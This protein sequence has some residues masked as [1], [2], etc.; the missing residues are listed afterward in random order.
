MSR[1]PDTFS[2]DAFDETLKIIR[3]NLH[4]LSKDAVIRLGDVAGGEKLRTAI[5]AYSFLPCSSDEKCESCWVEK[6][7]VHKDIP[8]ENKERLRKVLD[9]LTSP[10]IQL[11]QELIT[12]INHLDKTSVVSLGDLEGIVEMLNALK[13]QGE[14]LNDQSEDSRRDSEDENSVPSIIIMDG[15]MHQ[16]SVD[17]GVQERPADRD[18]ADEIPESSEQD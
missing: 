3:K 10:E 5:N 14:S 12:L 17:D 11:N 18:R 13:Q 9:A 1:P 16:E 7:C 4:R 15:T 2:A 8:S 6:W